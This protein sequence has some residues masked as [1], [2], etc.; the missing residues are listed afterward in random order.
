MADFTSDKDGVFEESL[1]KEEVAI[2]Q[3][4]SASSLL[5]QTEVVV[6]KEK[7]T[8]SSDDLLGAAGSSAAAAEVPGPRTA[9]DVPFTVREGS[10]DP[11]E[12]D[13][14]DSD[15]EVVDLE[16]ESDGEEA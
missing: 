13:I 6:G 4:L 9:E 15:S 14:S 7:K 1:S 10:P 11:V 12:V 3:R 16:E 8:W 2:L 5:Q